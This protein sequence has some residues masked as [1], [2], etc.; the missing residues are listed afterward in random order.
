MAIV[1]NTISDAEKEFCAVTTMRRAIE[2]YALSKN[3]SFDEAFFAFTKSNTYL[4][5]FD[6]ETAIWREG[7]D[8]LLN[9]FTDEL[10]EEIV[11]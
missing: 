2:K 11:A 4:A 10:N 3:I 8:Y 6:Y 5:L 1:N 7:P 9:L